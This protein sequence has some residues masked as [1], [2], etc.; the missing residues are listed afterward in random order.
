MT[1]PNQPELTTSPLYAWEIVRLIPDTKDEKKHVRC[2]MTIAAHTIDQVWDYLA[3][4]R[5]DERTEIESIVRFG[6][7]VAILK[8]EQQKPT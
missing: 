7:I 5:A 6:P 8:N 4:D 3:P 2:S 1:K